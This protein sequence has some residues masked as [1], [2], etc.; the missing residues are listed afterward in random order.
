MHRFLLL[1]AILACLPVAAAA[2][3]RVR[4]CAKYKTQ[5]AWSQ[6]YGVDATLMSGSD[7]NR[8]T[9]TFDYQGFSTYVVIFWGQ[10]QA[11][12]ILMDSPY[13]N[14]FGSDGED[15]EGRKWQIAETDFCI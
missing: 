13:L 9:H 15:Q 10:D 2:S 6:G 12:V 7:L 11:S 1:F 5:Y 14:A 4:V 8:A 3:E